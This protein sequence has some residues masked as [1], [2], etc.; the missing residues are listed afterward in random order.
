MA[1]EIRP[2]GMEDYPVK[3]TK[4]ELFRNICEDL[5]G[6]YIAKNEDYGDSFH[7]LYEKYG[8]I[9]PIIHIQEKLN[10]IESL[11]RKSNKVDGETYIDSLKDLANYAILTL[12][13]IEINK[14]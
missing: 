10:R 7:R 9:Y 11:Q 14:K 12:L 1:E 5:L 3:Q 8:M 13:E 6:K 4:E 2:F